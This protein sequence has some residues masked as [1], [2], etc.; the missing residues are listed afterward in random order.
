MEQKEYTLTVG[1][2]AITALFNNLADQADGSVIM[3][4]GETTLLVTAVMSKRESNANYL[5]LSVEYEERFYAS[6]HILGSR[7]MRREG[8]P[9]E[10]AILSGRVID[11]TIRPLF[12]SWI[13]QDIQVIVTVL[14]L[15][16]YDPDTLAV[17]GASLAI[18]TSS[19]PWNGPVSSVRIVHTD[20]AIAVNPTYTTRTNAHADL[21]VCGVAG[22]IN[23]IET[24]AKEVSEEIILDALTQAETEIQAIQAWQ[25]AII[26]ERG[27]EKKVF[28]KPSLPEEI[29]S[30]F[31]EH[32]SPKL[33][34][35]VM[36]NTPGKD[37]I[38]TLGSEWSAFVQEKFPK[39][40]LSLAEEYFEE[41]IDALIH[42]EAIENN[43][44]PD[45]RDF[46]TVRPLFAQA[47]GLSPQLHGSGI[48][49]RGGTHVFNALTLGGPNDSLI[50]D[51]MEQTGD[52]RFMHHYN[53]PPFAPGETGRVGGTNRR[54]I[55]HG[56]LAE[57][58]LLPVIPPKETF[59]YTIRLVSECFA[60]NGS[61]SMASVCAGTLA[62]MDG[63]VPIT[64]PVAG[65][66]S[67]LMMNKEGTYKVL[68]DIQGPED[69]HGDMDFKVAGTEKGI[70]AIQMDVKV[71]G[72][73]LAILKEALEK[74]RIA[75]MHILGVITEAIKEPRSSI[76][77]RAPKIIVVKI[78]PDHIGS[79][80]GSGG[81]TINAIRE[82]T[83]TEIDIEDDGTVSIT[84]KGNGPNEAKKIIED[85]T[86]VFKVGEDIEG[87]VVRITEFGAFVSLNEHTDGLLHISEIAPFRIQKTEEVLSIGERIPVRVIEVDDRGRLKLSLKARDPQYAE[88]KGVKAK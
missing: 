73:P 4:S 34:D 70:T 51:G 75:R 37:S 61:T 41:A 58:A 85:M 6:G 17:I 64:R 77:T 56:A 69:H 8:R 48:F 36:S 22:K 10:E 76:S 14:S 27:K 43:R 62:L 86:H 7:F 35:A 5:P 65:I 54:M 16:E 50:L 26:N 87:T 23:M 1:D 31:N 88:K 82:K 33:S 57:K 60:S 49:Y 74:A 39:E 66:A 3:R 71:A 79:I 12:D 40:S 30:T 28:A 84:G 9:S 72:I 46:D 81:K 13:R 83:Q 11:R 18:G 29:K 21:T 24:G 2:S 78:A 15:G 25:Q 67:G 38:N 42:H 68:T 55:G 32:I 52:K 45:G 20:N 53:F 63:G 59:P 44:R 19:I 80:I 47:G